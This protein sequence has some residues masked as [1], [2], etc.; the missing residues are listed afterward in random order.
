MKKIS[1]IE[2]FQALISNY[3][4]AK[5]NF[6]LLPE[7]CRKLIGA[8]KLFYIDTANTLFLFEARDGFY[9]FF[10]RFSKSPCDILPDF[11]LPTDPLTS[12]ITY[13]NAPDHT[14]VERLLSF[15]FQ[16]KHTQLRLSAANILAK[17]IGNIT[18]ATEDE[19]IAL[20]SEAF[21]SLT[22]DLPCRGMFHTLTAVRDTDGIPLGIIHYDH[23]KT[24]MLIAVRPEARGCGIGSALLGEFAEKSAHLPGDYHV[25]VVEDNETAFRLYKKLGFKP[26]G[27]KSDLYIL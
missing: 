15:G 19:A 21:P 5:T 10:L 9:K 23:T 14:I 17:S 16:R 25:W 1:G 22:S 20:F 7:Q 12:Y 4:R 8:Q 3:P 18:P 2:Q 11:Q 27:L 6:Y 26:E 13:R 24:V